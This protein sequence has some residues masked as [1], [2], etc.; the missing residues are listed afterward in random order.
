MT[1]SSTIHGD[2]EAAASASVAAVARAGVQVAA[3]ASTT[4]DVA[5]VTGT[6][7]A[8]DSAGKPLINMDNKKAPRCGAFLVLSCS[9]AGPGGKPDY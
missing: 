5:H 4:A 1:R 6:A 8:W 9:Q 3:P 7:A 2:E